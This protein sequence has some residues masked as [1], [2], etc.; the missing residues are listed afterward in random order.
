MF[1][2]NSIKYDANWEITNTYGNLQIVQSQ[3]FTDNPILFFIQ[4]NS[5]IYC[6][7][8]FVIKEYK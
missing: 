1:T 6:V 3:F 7:F 2:K 8:R 5:N 4:S